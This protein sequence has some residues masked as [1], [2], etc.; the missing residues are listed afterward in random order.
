MAAKAV[1]IPIPASDQMLTGTPRILYGWT[2]EETA[3]A[4]AEA[5]IRDGS[6]TGTILG[7]IKIGAASLNPTNTAWFGPDGVQ[8]PNGVFIDRVSGALAGSIFVG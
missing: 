4:A 2:I 5:L 1:A 7:V 8:A 6:A 3:A